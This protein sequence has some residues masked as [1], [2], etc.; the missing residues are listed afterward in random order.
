MPA[1]VPALNVLAVGAISRVTH[2]P[3]RPGSLLRHYRLAAAPRGF[4]R[5]LVGAAPLYLLQRIPRI[6]T[7]HIAWLSYVYARYCCCLPV[8]RQSTHLAFG[9]VLVDAILRPQQPLK[10]GYFTDVRPY[11]HRTCIKAAGRDTLR[12]LPQD[13]LPLATCP[14]VPATT[15]RTTCRCAFPYFNTA[16][17]CDPPSLVALRTR[18]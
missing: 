1:F 16:P 7:R 6:V 11:L 5:H 18:Y 10:R 2:S 8:V 15:T 3:R 14:A 17:P 12:T 4:R 9:T 13:E